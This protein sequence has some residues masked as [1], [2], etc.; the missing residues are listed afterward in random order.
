MKADSPNSERF[1]GY[2][3]DPYQNNG[4]LLPVGIADFPWLLQIP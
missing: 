4:D 1:G 2:G 3:G